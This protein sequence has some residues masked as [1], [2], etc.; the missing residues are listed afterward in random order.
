MAYTHVTPHGMR[1]PKK[2]PTGGGAKSRSKSSFEIK[3]PCGHS[4]RT[5]LGRKTNI[6]NKCHV[7]IPGPWS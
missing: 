1:K 5:E 6:C 3:C 4:Q 7:K 2:R